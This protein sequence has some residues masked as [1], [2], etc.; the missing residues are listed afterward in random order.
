[1]AESTQYLITKDTQAAFKD[2]VYMKMANEIEQIRSSVSMY[3]SPLGTMGGIHLLKEIVNNAIDEAMNEKS[4]TI[5]S[6]KIYVTFDE[7]SC[8]FTVTD[9]GRGIPLDLLREVVCEKHV[10]TKTMGKANRN[11]DL[12][13]MNGVGLTVVAALSDY[14]SITSY[15]GD[16]AK[17]LE[18]KDGQLVEGKPFRLKKEQYG[19][20]DVI[21][22]SE[23]YL[24]HMEITCDTVETYFRHMSYILRGEIQI[25]LEE[26]DAEG[27]KRKLIY[28]R[29]GLGENVNFLSSSLEFNPVEI[30]VENEDFGLEIAFSYDRTLNDTLCDSYTNYIITTEG[31]VHEQTA[32]RAICEFLARE[33]KKLDNSG[34]VEITYDDCK[35]G[36]VMAVNCRHVR[37]VLEGQHK[38]RF[39]SPD[40]AKNGRG[41]ITNALTTYFHNNPGLLRKIIGY[42]KQIAK[43]RL[44]ANKIKGVGTKQR[45]STFLEDAEIKGFSNIS[46]RYSK[47]YKELYICE[48]ESASGA[49]LNCRNAQYQALYGIMGVTDNVYD[50]SLTQLMKTT[51]FRNIIKILGCGVGS[52]FDIHKLRW[53]KIIICT[54]SDSDGR[55]ITS[56]LLCFFLC[57]MPELILQG[58]IYKAMPPLYV[59]KK[60][61]L[62]KYYKGREWLYDKT[63]LYSLFHDIISS[64]TEI[65]LGGK[66]KPKN[67]DTFH[68]LTKK[69]AMNWLMMNSEYSLELENLGKKSTCGEL[70]IEYVCYYK[71]LYGSN[72]PKFKKHIEEQFPEMEYDPKNQ[73]LS[74]S[75]QGEQ[76]SLICDSLFDRSAVRFMRMLS[77]NES[78]FVSVRGSKNGDT[79]YD[80]MTIG[81][82]F[83]LMGSKYMV[84]IDQRFKGLGEAEAELLFVTTMNPKLRKLLRITMP[85][86][87]KAIETFKILHQKSEAMIH[88]RRKLLDEAD[89]S[90]ADIDN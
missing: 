37:P 86:T 47:G 73:S 89:I 12:A 50:M 78:L 4:S 42:L 61:N 49:L 75:Y 45:V 28:K 72:T 41:M 18:F 55:N 74:G 9:E 52:E 71:L 85:D 16:K 60:D 14:M 87:K 63:E 34:K 77:Q 22:P 30:E 67:G 8:K 69:E 7:K 90:Y 36:L 76:F 27:H 31:G 2:D 35:R 58:K 44:E 83:D 62:R 23:K 66:K 82:F 17:T 6:K 1:M 13:G 40:V 51:V 32:Q 68:I 54:D 80:T 15:R 56:L 19:I 3:V 24:G 65:I 26:T 48:G 39:S 5:N 46:N 64:N 38:S 57:F 59:L 84:K 70:I 25:F 29:Q 79:K 33:A 43:A 53:N 21:M 11:K 20:S 81:Q 88:E 10:G